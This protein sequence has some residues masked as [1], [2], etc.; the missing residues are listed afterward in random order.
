MQGNAEIRHKNVLL[1]ADFVTRT[2]VLLLRSSV[3]S[4]TFVKGPGACS[5]C[6][7]VLCCP[8]SSVVVVS[9]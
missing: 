9:M 7:G 6:A 4:P 1:G 3:R 5:L 8:H 2:G